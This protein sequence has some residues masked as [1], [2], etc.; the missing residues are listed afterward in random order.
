MKR[1]GVFISLIFSISSF[2]WSSSMNEDFDENGWSNSK[3][4]LSN[5]DS[6][7]LSCALK[8]VKAIQDSL[9]EKYRYIAIV[10]F[11]KLSSE[12]RFYLIDLTDTTLVCVDFVCHG[13]YSGE[14]STTS[15]S[16]EFES[17]KSS[18]GFYKLSET[19]NGLHGLSIRMDGLDQGYN[20]NARQRA[21]VMHTAV[22]ADTSVI[23]ELGRLGRSLG[24][25]TLPLN[26]F[27]KIALKL[28]NNAIIFHYYPDTNY[29]KNSVWL[30]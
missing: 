29:L 18:L 22:Y 24:C 17:N 4:T 27:T 3:D 19:Y 20:N 13:K 1:L 25:P 7:A 8:G 26:T 30:H 5:V 10:D 14:N 16:N 28:S 12:Q 21:I 15:F 2:V 9:H 23:K 6:F 11:S